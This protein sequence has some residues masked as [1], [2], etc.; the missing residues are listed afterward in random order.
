MCSCDSRKN[1]SWGYESELDSWH[2]LCDLGLILSPLNITFLIWNLVFFS[3]PPASLKAEMNKGGGGEE[4]SRRGER[5]W[6]DQNLL[7]H[8]WEAGRATPQRVW[9]VNSPSLPSGCSTGPCPARRCSHVAP[10]PISRV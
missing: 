6:G 7:E 1:T 4:G 3:Q 5:K 2:D 9:W 10:T 8:V